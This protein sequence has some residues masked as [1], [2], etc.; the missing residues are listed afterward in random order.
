MAVRT[1]G[2]RKII[3]NNQL[4]IWY[5]S[6]HGTEWY[7]H[8]LHIVS[9]DKKL[10]LNYPLDSQI[11]Y[12]INCGTVFQNYKPNDCQA[13][14]LVPGEP[15][16]AASVGAVERLILWA[17]HGQNAARIEYCRDDMWL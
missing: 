9:A 16:T 15:I 7:H 10:I 4:Y 14:Y 11:S 2:R 1:K 17:V 12:A 13:R 5:V 3:V 8:I 6:E